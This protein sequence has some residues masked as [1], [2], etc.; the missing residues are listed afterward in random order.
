MNVKLLA[1][2][3]LTVLLLG[4]VEGLTQAP[5]DGAGMPQRGGRRG[6]RNNGFMPGQAPNAPA[7]PSADA[8]ALPPFAQDILGGG[9]GGRGGGGPGGGRGG[10]RGGGMFPGGGPMPGSPAQTPSGSDPGSP[11]QPAT[12]SGPIWIQQDAPAAEETRPVVYR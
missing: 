6:G 5:K 8:Q 9:S 12:G 1:L 10:R 3:G 4:P 2:V 11:A 7:Q